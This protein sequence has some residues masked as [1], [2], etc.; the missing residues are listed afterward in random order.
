MDHRQ[1]G[2]SDVSFNELRYGWDVRV[3]APPLLDFYL[4][5][6]TLRGCCE[7]VQ[8]GRS[9]CLAAGTAAVVNPDCDYAKRWSQDAVQLI[10][11]VSRSRLSCLLTQLLGAQA[12]DAIQFEFAARDFRSEVHGLWAAVKC[13]ALEAGSDA[14]WM[15]RSLHVAAVDHLLTL[16]L[17]TMRNSCGERLESD[18]EPARPRFLQ[19]AQDYIQAHA[20]DAFSLAQLCEVAGVAPR[21]L[22]RGFQQR[23]GATPFEYV[24]RVR[25]EFARRQ[26]SSATS[27]DVRIADVALECGYVN[28]GR[29]ARDYSA[30]YGERPSETRRRTR[31]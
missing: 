22:H 11:R 10:V 29:F 31:R 30:R 24:R 2:W 9:L 20:A 21:T 14:I 26:L 16:L 13:I 23:F 8:R 28:F 25:L 6:F 4:L 1:S 12:P 19:R 7:I 15:R 17:N 3:E 5:Q 18:T 27:A